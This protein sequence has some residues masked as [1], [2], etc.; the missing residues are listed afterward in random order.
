MKELDKEIL[1]LEKSLDK[2]KIGLGGLLM[3]DAKK[4]NLNRQIMCAQKR[5]ENSSTKFNS[6]LATNA[7]LRDV[8]S[9]LQHERKTF[10]EIHKKTQALLLDT[11]DQTKEVRIY[12]S[13]CYSCTLYYSNTVETGRKMFL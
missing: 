12:T 10:Y 9:H 8:I 5:L 6:T 1:G 4:S 11:R 3:A 7:R 2:Q 13:P